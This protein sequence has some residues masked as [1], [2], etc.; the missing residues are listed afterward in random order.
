LLTMID[1]SPDPESFASTDINTHTYIWS[2]LTLVH[3]C[4][5]WMAAH[6]SAVPLALTTLVKFCNYNAKNNNKLVL[7]TYNRW[8]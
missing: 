3:Y 8:N 1:S 2:A 5:K 7:F 4:R 6:C